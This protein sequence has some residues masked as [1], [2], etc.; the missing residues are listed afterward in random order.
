M[1]VV[2][3]QLTRVRRIVDTVSD[4]NASVI[5]KLVKMEGILDS[6]ADMSS[7]LHGKMDSMEKEWVV[8][9]SN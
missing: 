8:S 7:R 5:A 2:D 1:M 4:L 9:F 6:L 3:A